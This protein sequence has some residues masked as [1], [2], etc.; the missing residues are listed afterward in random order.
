[1]RIIL[2]IALLCLGALPLRV[3]AASPLA[4]G[5]AFYREGRLEAARAAFVRAVQTQPRQATPRF[6]LGITLF[7]QARYGDAAQVLEG[8]T[9][10]APRDAR[11]WLWWGHALAMNHSADARRVLTHV[12]LLSPRGPIADRAKQ[13]LRGLEV[14]ARP[15][16]P[17]PAEGGPAVPPALHPVTYQ[18]V[19][20]FYNPRLTS[21][22]A[23][24]IAT[25]ILG[26][27]RQYRIDPRLVASVIAIES[28]FSPA[29]RSYKG[30]MGL[31]QL[32]PDTAASLGVHPYD[33]V[34]NVYGTVRVLR[35]NLD[36]FGW[37]N[38]YLALAAYNAGKGAVERYGG[39][40]PYQETV[41]Y[42]RL[43][44]DLYRRFLELYPAPQRV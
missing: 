3:E 29:A 23:A 8:A 41:L 31:G 33:P 6:W 20:R 22:Q 40:P 2:L 37:D 15:A 4:Q 10:L 12:L 9:T 13:G 11:I 32:M 7:A 14:P 18:T 19:A 1:M 34:Q 30:A 28:G 42:V 36:R 35:G 25:A 44:G 24:A 17:L 26:Y 43:V 21:P 27:S 16:R 38:L 5:I 39:I